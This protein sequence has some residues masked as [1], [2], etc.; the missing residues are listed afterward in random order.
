MSNYAKYE[1]CVQVYRHLLF[2]NVLVFE[3]WILEFYKA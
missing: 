1:P 2:Y 3:V